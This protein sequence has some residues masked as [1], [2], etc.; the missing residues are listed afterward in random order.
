MNTEDTDDLEVGLGHHGIGRI[1]LPFCESFGPFK[2]VNAWRFGPTEALQLVDCG[3]PGEAA[4]AALSE[5]LRGA[6]LARFIAS[7]AHWDHVGQAGRVCQLFDVPL[8]ISGAEWSVFERQF[9]AFEPDLCAFLSHCGEGRRQSAL[10]QAHTARMKIP[11]SAPDRVSVLEAATTTELAGLDWDV[12]VWSG[13]SVGA[14]VFACKD[15]PVVFV[16]DQ[17]FTGVTPFVGVEITDPL[18]DP[19]ATQFAFLDR[20]ASLPDHVIC[21]P[22]HGSPFTRAS[23]QAE[24]QRASLL[25]RLDRMADT[26]TSPVSCADLVRGLSPGAE[27]KRGYIVRLRATLGLLNHLCAI[28][29]LVR[30]D[31]GAGRGYSFARA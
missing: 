29:T 8:E 12:E 1:V 27:A 5:A 9:R 10:L 26:V 20:I 28:G 24:G 14:F 19:L 23:V 16:G 3:P 11:G 25:R 15:A 6:R 4:F 31:R 22:G 2:Q 13:H 30:E 7:H 18:A 17:L 21:L